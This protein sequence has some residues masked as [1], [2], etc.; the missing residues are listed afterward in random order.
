MPP[1]GDEALM[2]ACERAELELASGC[3]A[4]AVIGAVIPAVE[5]LASVAGGL[6]VY[7]LG[8]IPKSV[9]AA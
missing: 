4:I 5:M 7:T 1:Y 3:D 9:T 8:G 2:S 6:P